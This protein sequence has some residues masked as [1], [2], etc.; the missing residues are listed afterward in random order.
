MNK[1]IS[2]K[3]AENKMMLRIFGSICGVLMIAYII[4]IVKG[5]RGIGYTALFFTLLLTPFIVSLVY[6]IKNPESKNIKRAALF[7]Y[8][9]F[10]AFSLLTSATIISFTYILPMLV[11]CSL[12]QNTK[13]TIRVSIP[14]FLINVAYIAMR[15]VSGK[16]EAA[17]I[18]NF[19][20]QIAIIVLMSLFLIYVNQVLEK[21]SKIEMNELE[22]EKK[23]SDTIA[24]TL[25]ESTKSIS[26]SAK[27]V[28]ERLSSIK[29]NGN[30]GLT[31]MNE[32]ADGTEELATT[33][34][35]QLEKSKTISDATENLLMQSEKVSEAMK[36]TSDIMA[37]G[38]TAMNEIKTLAENT[39]N[40]S[41]DVHN[42]LETLL[43]D[44]QKAFS[45]L[46]SVT[47]ITDQTKI[48]ALNASIEAARAGESGRGFAVVAHEI[49]EL[50]SQ[51]SK[52][53]D[54]IQNIFDSLNSSVNKSSQSITELISAG[55]VQ[56]KDILKLADTFEKISH[57]INQ[58]QDTVKAMNEQA[59]SV[60]QSNKEVFSGVENLSAFSEELL[61]NTESTK[62]V[63]TDVIDNTNEVSSEINNIMGH[64]EHMSQ[65]ALG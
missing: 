5:N 47:Q 62:A 60:S 26:D 36:Q 11:A 24:N 43:E 46:K 19:E 34:Q 15:F 41:S 16:P 59:T 13:F 40:I 30:A 8:L 44:T 25:T 31:S 56:G 28:N 32:I 39:E 9:I 58:A 48:L 64:I 42:N 65:T 38:L 29:N 1:Q 22:S 53:T 18:T 54:M 6:Y 50:A 17:E 45:I 61:S 2:R 20:I 14:S 10:Y 55:N 23:K 51:T 57:H 3:Q 21:F 52:A 35:G 7:G 49:G 4:E 12:Y 27:E 37:E 33:I 63:I